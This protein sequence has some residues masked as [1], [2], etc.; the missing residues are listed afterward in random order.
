MKTAVFR[1]LGFAIPTVVVVTALHLGKQASVG[2]AID[3][4]VSGLAFVGFYFVG[5]LLTLPFGGLRSERSPGRDA[6]IGVVAGVAT[7]ILVGVFWAMPRTDDVRAG[8]F[9]I[10]ALAMV[11]AAFATAAALRKPRPRVAV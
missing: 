11:I 5:E 4:V 7:W 9:G 3:G 8:A 6:L 10:N 1:A 2:E